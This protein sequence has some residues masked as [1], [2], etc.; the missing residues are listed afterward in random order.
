MKILLVEDEFIQANTICNDLKSHFPSIDVDRIKTESEFRTRFSSIASNPPDLVIL[1]IMLKW[2]DPQPNIDYPDEV[3]IGGAYR[4]GLRC[5]K[6]LIQDERTSGI[7]VILYSNLDWV[8]LGDEFKSL[9]PNVVFSGKKTD[10]NRF[11]DLVRSLLQA[12]APAPDIFHSV[13]IVHGRDEGAK[14]SVAR[15]LEKLGLNP[16]ILHER[17]SKGRT[18]IEKFEDYSDVVFAVVLLTPDDVGG[19]K[20]EPYEMKPR[21][22]Q[23]VIF[24]LGFFVGKLGRRNVCALHRDVEIPSDFHGVV[25]ID[26]DSTGAWRSQLAR[27]MD[28]AGLS[29]DLNR[30]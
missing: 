27:E 12:A 15:F 5:L 18:I 20:I 11:I 22:R 16:I 7:P 21:A 17:A 4:A 10:A 2:T 25:Y 3:K 1:D 19:P 8:N 6:I 14:E 13:F 28:A 9:P 29:I 26:M 30:I 23:N 24:E